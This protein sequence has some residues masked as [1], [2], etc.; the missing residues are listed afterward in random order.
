MT[1]HKFVMK[2]G[3]AKHTGQEQASWKWSI[4]THLQKSGENE[5]LYKKVTQ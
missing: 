1:K 5:S 4:E 3:A 2:R